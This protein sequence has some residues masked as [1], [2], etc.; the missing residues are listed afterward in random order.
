[1][2]DFLRFRKF[3]TPVVIEGIFWLLVL[4]SLVM[5]IVV[6][7]Q[8]NAWGLAMIFL[9]PVFARI[10]CELAMVQFGIYDVLHHIRDQGEKRPEGPAKHA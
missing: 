2:V 4:L 7:V 9:G 3:V 10:A 8:G 1:M 5:G 6:I